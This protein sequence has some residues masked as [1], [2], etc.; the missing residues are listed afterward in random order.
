MNPPKN[1]KTLTTWPP[2]GP[3]RQM[4]RGELTKATPQAIE[5]ARKAGALDRILRGLPDEESAS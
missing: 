3:V 4:T 5:E 2:P 1:P